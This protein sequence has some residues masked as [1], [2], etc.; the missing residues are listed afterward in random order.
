MSPLYAQYLLL[1]LALSGCAYA[2]GTVAVYPE[3]SSPSESQRGLGLGDQSLPELADIAE[4]ERRGG[5]EPGLGLLES[6]IRERRG[7]YP[8]AVLAAYKELRYAYGRGEIGLSRVRE[9]VDRLDSLI[10]DKD[11]SGSSTIRS[12]VAAVKAFESG[13]WA[14]AAKDLPSL[15]SPDDAPDSFARWMASVCSLE[16]GDAPSSEQ[17]RYAVMQARYSALPDYWYRFARAQGSGAAARD[18]AERCIAL[19]PTGPLALGARAIV[20]ESYGL[21]R[22]CAASL[23]T[24]YEIE[25]AAS[26]AARDGKPAAL[27]P[28]LAVLGLPDNPATLYAVGIL[29]GM[30]AAQPVRA[31]LEERGAVSEGRVAERLRYVCAR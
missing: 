4:A 26:S 2:G 8:G 22:S 21:E 23:L 9:G 7:D 31:W 14:D 19:A 29:R 1:G 15:S 27:E 24:A 18:S 12:A 20:A 13:D 28:L 3:T 17:G 6:S 10:T 5:Y 16:R 30:C 25:S 11:H